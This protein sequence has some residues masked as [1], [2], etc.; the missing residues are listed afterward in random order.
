MNRKMQYIGEIW[1]SIGV[2]HV[3]T[4]LGMGPLLLEVT[5]HF[6]LTLLLG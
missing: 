4:L 2:E 3:H 6:V 1:G 5:D